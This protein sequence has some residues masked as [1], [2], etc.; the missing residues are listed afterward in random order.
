MI[1]KPPKIL[2]ETNE[3][4]SSVENSGIQKSDKL[5]IVKVLLVIKL[6]LIELLK[7]ELKKEAGVMYRASPN[8]KREQ[9][10]FGGQVGEVS[11]RYGV[12]AGAAKNN[13]QDTKLLKKH[14]LIIQFIKQHSGRVSA[15]KLLE[16]NIAGRTLRRYIKN[17]SDSG[18][19]SV[20]K[21][22]RE[23]FYTVIV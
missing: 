7:E 2:R 10:A 4:I 16:L 12:G 14:A 11:P 17:L 5:K 8:T 6:K 1:Q 22:G 19:V 15:T 21:K 3:L 9:V 13:G 20:E 18:K 23:H